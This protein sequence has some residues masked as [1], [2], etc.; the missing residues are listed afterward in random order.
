MRLKRKLIFYALILSGAMASATQV[1]IK[2]QLRDLQSEV[3]LSSIVT[4]AKSE[5]VKL[6]WNSIITSIAVKPGQKVKAGDLI[7]TSDVREANEQKSYLETRRAALIRDE[8]R[9]REEF[10]MAKKKQ[11]TMNELA[12]KD[13]IPRVEAEKYQLTI[14]EGRKS[15]IQAQASVKSIES[16]IANIEERIRAANY[17]APMAGIISALIVDPKQ[18]S[19]TLLADPDSLLAKID[20][21]FRFMAVAEVMDTQVKKIEKIKKAEVQLEGSQE[22]YQGTVTKISPAADPKTGLF[23]V[24][25]E[26][27]KEGAP[28]PAGITARIVFKEGI[29]QKALALPWNAVQVEGNKAWVISGSGEK[30]PVKL[31]IRTRDRVEIKEGIRQGEEVEAS[32]W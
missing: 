28:I 29:T 22:I 11:V 27:K 19:G 32:M 26:F 25:V 16:E 13:V 6:G 3:Q 18:F 21:P 15:V 23:K 20:E 24:V 4:P 12:A 1:I 14:L 30:K 7:A 5:V 17:Y 10:E 2:P 8:R 31:G 9:I